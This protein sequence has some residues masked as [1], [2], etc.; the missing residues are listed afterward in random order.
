MTLEGEGVMAVANDGYATGFRQSP[1]TTMRLSVN[2]AGDLLTLGNKVTLRNLEIVDLDGRSGNVIAVTSRRQRDTVSVI[3]SDVVVVN[4][5]PI[6]IMPGGTVGRGLLVIT[7]N[8]NAKADPPPDDGSIL[9]VKLLRSVIKSTTTGGGF[10]AFNFAPN[11]RISL[12]I[13]HSSIG[14]SSEANGGVS[15][16][17]QVHDSEVRVTSQKNIYINEQ[18]DR[19]AVNSLGLNLNGGSGAPIGVKISQALRNRLVVRSVDDRIDGFKTAVLA[20]GGRSFY[21]SS[22][23][24]PPKDNHIELQLI[25]TTISTPSCP[26]VRRLVGARGTAAAADER[27]EYVRDFRL[28]GSEIVNEGADTGEGNSVRA[29]LRGITGSGKRANRFA[30]ADAGYGPLPAKSQG[31]GNRLE[32]VGDPETFARTNR[33][34]DPQPAAQFFTP[35]R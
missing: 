23:N 9:L 35:R 1:H 26:P 24:P 32:I 13:S 18:P 5:N 6:V 31:K 3:I 22:L 15:R 27:S 11:S 33:R 19:C 30:N 16:P 8:A 17:D 34:I 2:V 12:D 28:I 14:G 7:R 25:G 4:P 21:A 10:F 20:T 29:E